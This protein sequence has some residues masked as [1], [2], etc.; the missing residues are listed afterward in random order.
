[1]CCVVIFIPFYRFLISFGISSLNHG[2]FRSVLFNLH[3]FGDCPIAFLLLISSMIPLCAVY[4]FSS[5]QFVE[6]CLTA[7]DMLCLDEYFMDT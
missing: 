5:F 7:E 4:D 2:V 1:M 6:V 3:G